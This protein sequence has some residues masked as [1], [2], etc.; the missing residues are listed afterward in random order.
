MVHHTFRC[1]ESVG[2]K[3]ILEE[4]AEHT[5]SWMLSRQLIRPVIIILAY[6]DNLESSNDVK[7]VRWYDALEKSC[8]WASEEELGMIYMEMAEI[9]ARSKT[10]HS[11]QMSRRLCVLALLYLRESANRSYRLRCRT[12]AIENSFPHEQVLHVRSSYMNY[13]ALHETSQDYLR[14]GHYAIAQSLLL[15]AGALAARSSHYEFFWCF[16]WFTDNVDQKL[17]GTRMSMLGKLFQILIILGQGG[18]ISKVLEALNGVYSH[19]VKLK[20]P[21]ISGVHAAACSTIYRSLNK[22][23]LARFWAR[24]C[25]AWWRRC[26]ESEASDG[27]EMY[28]QLLLRKP[29]STDIDMGVLKARILNQLTKD[30]QAQRWKNVARELSLLAKMDADVHK[31]IPSAV[32]LLTTSL[33]MISSEQHH[34]ERARL[35]DMVTVER[36]S[37]L[38]RDATADSRTKVDAIMELKKMVAQ[39]QDHSSLGSAYRTL[40]VGSTLLEYYQATAD[41]T[42]NVASL[43][44]VTRILNIAMTVFEATNQ[45]GACLEAAYLHALAWY[46]VWKVSKA[47]EI[48]KKASEAAKTAEAWFDRRRREL[49]SMSGIYAV[50]AKQTLA[51]DGRAASISSM[52][53]DLSVATRDGPEPLEPWLNVVNGKARSISDLLSMGNKI[54]E[55]LLWKLEQFYPSSYAALQTHINLMKQING[56]VKPEARL[57]LRAVNENYFIRAMEDKPELTDI[58]AAITAKGLVTSDLWN[59][60]KLLIP[61]GFGEHS[62]IVFIDWFIY[63]NRLNMCAISGAQPT[64]FWTLDISQQKVNNWKKEYFE[65]KEGLARCLD[66]DFED[67]EAPF[68]QLDALVAPLAEYV[69][70]DDLLILMPC[71]VLHGVPL[72]ALNIKPPGSSWPMPLIEHCK[73]VY[74]ASF[75]I[76]AQCLRRSSA[77]LAV[78]EQP[79]NDIQ[80]RKSKFSFVG[81]YKNED[82]QENEEEN[83]IHQH[84][85]QLASMEDEATFLIGD[86]ATVENFEKQGLDGRLIHFHGHC[87]FDVNNVLDQALIFHDPGQKE[88]ELV[89]VESPLDNLQPLVQSLPDATAPV[90]VG[91]QTNDQETSSGCDVG[92]ALVPQVPEQE[93]KPQAQMTGPESPLEAIRRAANEYDDADDPNPA[94]FYPFYHSQGLDKCTLDVIAMICA[95]SNEESE[96]IEKELEL[97]S[98]R[99]PHELPVHRAFDLKLTGQFGSII[100][101]VACQSGSERFGLG[102]EPL[103]LATGFLCAGASSV[104]GTLWKVD[105]GPARTFSEVFYEQLREQRQQRSF[106]EVRGITG[107][108]GDEVDLSLS[109]VDLAELHRTAVRELMSDDNTRN[110]RYW[111]PFMLTGSPFAL[112]ADAKSEDV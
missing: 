44:D 10:A 94:R 90:S 65:S 15:N 20:I 31:D 9:H 21:Y 16:S 95:R 70:K 83:E 61:L 101:L 43:W 3:Q 97:G 110:Y 2:M 40:C 24:E 56:E 33:H 57:L 45:T 53:F 8:E 51:K 49:S 109:L 68:R 92:T 84:I 12:I 81:V 26:T 59:V 69:K 25:W 108:G 111:A 86:E 93:A 54:P 99:Q 7:L 22:I 34:L 39:D 112:W 35:I 30:E 91:T 1:P 14:V 29:Y 87:N 55:T 23:H 46:A 107:I 60:Y 75:A 73:I 105:S 5:V 100:M 11:V 36:A 52:A 27:A 47:A 88:D 103:G 38:L 80:Y 48:A 96:A 19:V 17:E 98:A 28:Y 102:D 32:K 79:D 72:H 74:S 78:A 64:K 4:H 67:P 106:N 71:Q 50:L 58:Q 77:G 89:A 82:N 63:L 13:R 66:T 42:H 62:R 76:F 6:L 85:A 37:Y 18:H 104:M 41:R